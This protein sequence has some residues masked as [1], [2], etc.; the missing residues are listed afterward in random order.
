[1]NLYSNVIEDYV[2]E[3]KKQLNHYLSLILVIGSSSSNKV[4]E[5]WSDIDVI[6]VVDKYDF[7]IIEKIKRI[8]NSYS[9]KI[10]TTVYTDKEFLNKNIDPKTYY[11]L[12]LLQNNKIKLQYVKNNFNIPI[13]TFEEIK[14]THIPYINW[15]LHMYK[16]MF[17]YD[18]LNKEQYKNL[19]KM[20]YLIMKANLILD[21]FFPKN[22]DEVFKLFSQ[23]YNFEY[24]DYEK[25]IADYLN[26]SE[27]YKKIYEYS[28]MFLLEIIKK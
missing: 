21:G 1:M 14:A 22:Y 2:K 24:F 28:K 27:D 20:T 23:Q 11:H 6:L 8:S 16:R 5:R 13:V 3:I 12:Y 9:V 26:N 19:F 7:N 17:L 25:F 10:G 15:R 4:M 18:C